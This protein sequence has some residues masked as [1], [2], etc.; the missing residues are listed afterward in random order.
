MEL[1]HILAILIALIVLVDIIQMKIK[2]NVF[3]AHRELIQMRGI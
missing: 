2:M 1:F 3:F